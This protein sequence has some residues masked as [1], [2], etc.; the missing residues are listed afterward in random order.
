[1]IDSK[2][3]IQSAIENALAFSAN[4]FGL[5]MVDVLVPEE[6][7]DF[8]KTSSD[9]G[10]VFWKPIPADINEEDLVLRQ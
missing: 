2:T 10:I 9:E 7:R 1:M 5:Q 8:S 4:R 6:M 3:R